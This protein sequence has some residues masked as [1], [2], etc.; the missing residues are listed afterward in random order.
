VL[1]IGWLWLLLYGFPGQMT[2]DTFEHLIEARAGNYT[3]ATP[4]VFTLLF[5]WSDATFGGQVGIFLLQVTVFVLAVYAT[6]RRLLPRY[7]HWWALALC[8]YPPILTTLQAVWKDSLMPGMLLLGFAG[9][10]DERRWVRVLALV[11]LFVAIAIR[12]NAFAAAAPLAVLLFVWRPGLH[13]IKRTAIGLVAWMAISGA[14][15]V[16]DTALADRK[17]HAWLSGPALFDIAGTLKYVDGTMSDAEIAPILAGTGLRID[18]DIHATIRARYRMRNFFNLVAPPDNV[19]EIPL[20]EVPPSPEQREAIA[21]AWS[22]LVGDHPAAYMAHRIRVF[23][24]CLAWQHRTEAYWAVPEYAFG[25]PFTAEREGISTSTTALQDTMNAAY[26]WLWHV[27]P[28]FEPWI[29]F[30]LALMLLWLARKHRDVLA[31]LLSGIGME[32]TLLFLAP[33]PDYRYSHW[34]VTCVTISVIVLVARRMRPAPQ[35]LSEDTARDCDDLRPVVTL[36]E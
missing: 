32:L 30:A 22:K 7:A 18:K 5:A 36:V 28:M 27:T 10:L 14:A 16:A 26:G 1:A 24:E 19:W 11:P 20:R 13:W 2:A 8:L 4:P 31:L 6:M 21:R 12:Y 35:E 15:Y 23:R 3:D 25:Y 29:Y 34:M 17:M 33:S 9:L